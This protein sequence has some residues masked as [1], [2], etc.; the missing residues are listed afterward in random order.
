[1]VAFQT[2]IVSAKLECT[3]YESR[4]IHKFHVLSLHGVVEVSS[5]YEM[6]DMNS[7]SNT[8]KSLTNPHTIR[9]IGT[10]KDV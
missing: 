6:E 8:L 9:G 4:D 2:Q 1:M 10:L 3:G 7:T 5:L